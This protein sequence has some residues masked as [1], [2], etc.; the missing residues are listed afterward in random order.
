MGLD[1]EARMD[2]IMQT[3]TD[4]L[5]PEPEFGEA[6]PI[7]PSQA[8]LDFLARR[9]S[10]SAAT[11]R[12]PA[13]S[14]EQ[15]RDLLRLAVRVP[16]HGKLAPWRFILLEGEAKARFVDK[17]EQIAD[18]SVDREKRKGALFKLKIPPMAVVVVSH[19]I[20]GKIP[21][22]EQ[23]MSSAAVCANLIIAAQAMGFGA[24]WITDWYAYD[25][26]ATAL[27]GLTGDERVSGFVYLGTPAEPPQERVRPE[28]EAL[29]S[30][31][32]G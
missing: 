25:D 20:E 7:Q 31:W 11:L 12:A 27:L 24:N 15:L 9:R 18:A 2:V 8:V 32:G 22:W 13:P 4:R 14:A 21:E 5:P 28:V 30:R 6:L 16:D 19:Y 3:L 17:L 29:V 23:R 26:Q 10:A 1:A